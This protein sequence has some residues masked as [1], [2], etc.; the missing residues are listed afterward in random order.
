MSDTNNNSTTTSLYHDKV[1]PASMKGDV[2]LSLEPPPPPP[3][4]RPNQPPQ[5]SGALVTAVNSGNGSELR[6]LL[7]VT[8]V[9]CW[10]S[11]VSHPS[12]YLLQARCR[13]Q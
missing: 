12:G 3:P 5:T 11:G 4:P 6:R 8:S 7:I 2:F 10:F 1:R 9:K 13:F